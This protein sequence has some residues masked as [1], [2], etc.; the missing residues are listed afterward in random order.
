MTMKPSWLLHRSSPLSL[1]QSN[2]A[3]E[4]S[5]RPGRWPTDPPRHGRSSRA[6][7]S[8][9]A[10]DGNGLVRDVRLGSVDLNKAV[11]ELRDTCH[12]RLVL[13][14]FYFPSPAQKG[15]GC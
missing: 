9:T 4:P 10:A 8:A 14:S 2:A 7:G 15:V 1:Q 11:L 6:P 3:V 13:Y 5:A 12:N